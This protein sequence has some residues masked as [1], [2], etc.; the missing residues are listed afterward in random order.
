MEFD[1]IQKTEEE[2][3]KLTTVQMQLL[4]TAQKEK[5]QLRHKLE[6]EM[7][8]FEQLVYTDGMKASS[9]IAQK[10]AELEKEFNYELEILVEQ[11]NYNL[12]ISEPLPPEKGDG[13][14]N[15]GYIVDY[16]LPYVDRYKIVR[17]YYL[18]IP[19]SAERMALY[20]AD[21]TAKRYLGTYYATLYDV[22][23]SYSK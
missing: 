16:S 11:L 9:L 17:D 8:L 12:T 23:Y 6:Q 7:E 20:S 21:E 2:L 14:E 22:L 5:N 10:R 3:K 13:D 1:I 19:N 18:S 4:R 15:A